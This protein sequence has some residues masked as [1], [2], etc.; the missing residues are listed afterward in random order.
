MTNLEVIEKLIELA[1]AARHYSG[2][3]SYYEAAAR[4]IAAFVEV[5]GGNDDGEA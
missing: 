5:N 3:D 1:A 4:A 2:D